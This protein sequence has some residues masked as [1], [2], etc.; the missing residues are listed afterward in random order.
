MED[1][2]RLATVSRLLSVVTAL[3]LRENRVLA[4]LVLGDL[5]GADSTGSY[6]ISSPGSAYD[7]SDNVRVLL[8]GLTLAVYNS[9][10]SNESHR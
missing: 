2:L 1:R 10:I 9:P 5:V 4:L 8:A 3:A 7:P 6:K